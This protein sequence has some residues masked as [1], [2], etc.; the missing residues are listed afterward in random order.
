M[1]EKPPAKA[2]RPAT[3]STATGNPALR[4]MGGSIAGRTSTRNR[5]INKTYRTTKSQVQAALSQL[6]CLL[7]DNWLLHFDASI[8]PLSQE[9]GA[10]E[11]VHLG[12]PSRARTF[13]CQHDAPENH[14]LPGSTTW[15]WPSR[16]S[17][18]FS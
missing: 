14:H 16:I 8:R 15:R 18:P 5:L 13:A 12:F 17:R 2:A 7:D 4:M 9:E 1:A 3:S 10:A 6:A 11:M